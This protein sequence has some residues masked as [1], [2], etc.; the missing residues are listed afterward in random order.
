MLSLLRPTDVE[1]HA[2]A[3]L[4]FCWHACVWELPAGSYLSAVSHAVHAAM[5]VYYCMAAA[6]A[7]PPA[8]AALDQVLQ[9]AQMAV[10]VVVTIS[11]IRM[12]LLTGAPVSSAEHLPDLAAA[13]ELHKRCFC[14]IATFFITRLFRKKDSEAT[15]VKTRRDLPTLD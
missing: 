7:K 13:A 12:T 8:W 14:L 6:C 3:T 11:H 1:R 9:F 5:L 4:L 10:S 15:P 2:F